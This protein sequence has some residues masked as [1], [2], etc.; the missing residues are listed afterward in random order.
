MAWPPLLAASGS[1]PTAGTG[2]QANLI[3]TSARSDGTRQVTYG[4]HPLY[5]FSGDRTATDVNGQ[6]STAFGAKWYVVAPTGKKIDN[7]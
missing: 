6:G 4:G 1:M 2:L 5:D 7:S 3:S